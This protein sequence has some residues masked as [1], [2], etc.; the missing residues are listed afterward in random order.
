MSK[1]YLLRNQHQQYLNKNGDWTYDLTAKDV[2][3][4]SH[5]DEVIN[6]K[7]ELSVRDAAL[8]IFVETA[9]F[10]Q[11]GKLELDESHQSAT[12]EFRTTNLNAAS[13]LNDEDLVEHHSDASQRASS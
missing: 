11:Q 9:S 10:N 5:K 6:R 1:I 8:R 3:H 12:P 13:A 7:V 4:T 2:Y